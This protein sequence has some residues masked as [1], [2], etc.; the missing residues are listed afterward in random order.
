MVSGARR[1][2]RDIDDE[3]RSFRRNLEDAVGIMIFPTIVKAGF[4]VGVE[5][6]TGVLLARYEDLD[7]PPDVNP[8][9]YDWSAPVFYSLA[10]ASFGLQIGA[11]GSEVIFLFM[12]ERAFERALDGDFEFG[13]EVGVT[14]FSED[15]RDSTFEGANVI[16]YA[17]SNGL[18]AGIAFEG[19]NVAEIRDGADAFYGD[20]FRGEEIVEDPEITNDDADRLRELLTELGARE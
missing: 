20:R 15:A 16:S 4:F 12:S 19:A 10:A 7:F 8:T 11:S 6:G 17:L 14:A 2:V 9:P 5:G 18:F 3:I 13:A 1:T